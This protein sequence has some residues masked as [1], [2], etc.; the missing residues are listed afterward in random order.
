[1]SEQRMSDPIITRDLFDQA[2]KDTSVFTADVG[3]NE[4]VVLQISQD[5]NE[6]VW[7]REKRLKSLELFNKTAFPNWGPS[8]AGLDVHEI[9]YFVKPDAKKDSKSWDDV[10]EDIKKTFDRLGIPEAEQKYLSGVGAQYDSINVYHSLKKEW[11]EQGVIFED[12]DIAVKKYPELVR[13]HFMTKCVPINDHKFIMLHAAVWSGGTFIY[14]PKGV[15]VTVPL[16]AYF[17]MNAKKGGQ[18][19]HT[20][21]IADEDAEVHYIEGCFTKGTKVTTNPDFK[22]IE[23]ISKADKVLT[24]NGEYKR[25]YHVHDRPLYSGNL[26]KIKIWGD[27]TSEIECTQEH[28]FLTVR[29]ERVNE[30]NRTWLANW[31]QAQ[32]ID[33]RDYLLMPINRKV[34]S[35]PSMEFIVPFKNK[36]IRQK[37]ALDRDFF[38]LIGYYLAEGSI[39]KNSY[40]SFS[41]GIHEA[42]YVN[43]VKR[44]LKKMGYSK[45][46]EIIH[47]KNNGV[48]V[49]LG[50]A[51]LARIFKQ[52]GTSAAKKSVPLWVMQEDPQKQKELI[53]GLFRGDGNYF[54]VNYKIGVKEAIRLN[55]ISEKLARQTRD[56]LLR[57][58]VFSFLNKRDRS[59]E[60]RQAMYTVGV[61]G[62]YMHTMGGLLGLNIN[63]K[64]NGKKR[65]TMFYIDDKYAYV[66]IRSIS[67]RKVE[68]IQVYNF[69]VENDETYTVNGIAVH[70]CSAPQYGASSLH[71]GCVE[72]FVY[73]NAR[74]RYSSVENWSKNTYNLNTKR[75]LVYENG[76]VE[77]IGGNM[78]SGCTMLYPSSILI[79][80]NAK[81]D[82][83][84]IAFAGA[85]QNQDTGSKVVHIGKNTTSTVKSKSISKLGGISSYRGLLSIKKGATGAKANVSCDALL[86]DPQSVSN[87]YP[88]LK[89]E[90]EDVS[91]GHEATVGKISDDDI[92]YLRSRG[93]S[94]EE[95]MQLIVSGFIEPIIKALPLEYAVELNKL[96]DME[97]IGSVG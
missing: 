68:K 56:I 1:M 21:I 31:V 9:T 84:G 79:G 88:T 43:D 74:I 28:P 58:N 14:V 38:R 39:I 76:V 95:A 19:E 51:K 22:P 61:T 49:V 10:P 57:L 34:V 64:I 66:P 15:K 25:V 73:K 92:F 90:E 40:L 46:N 62:E 23:L 50:D 63:N 3:L 69:A 86:L 53:I 41:F 29:R 59:K 26:Y 2:D 20:L 89:V 37:V 35:S 78:G 82:H 93:L 30:R 80:D 72:L 6:P 55:T 42:E 32:H 87:T 85:G 94:Q 16:Q 52:F 96:I 70:N 4:K 77:W 33:R 44:I 27:A 48:S 8:L 81:A 24:H 47:K 36:N 45:T 97:M 12:M 67:K 71:A 54:N 11:E 18:F 17:R 75:A 5:K 91:I 13:K 65:A 83:L 7:V 60:G